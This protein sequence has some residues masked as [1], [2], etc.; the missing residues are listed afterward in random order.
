LGRL[1]R[2]RNGAIEALTATLEL[3]PTHEGAHFALSLLYAEAGDR[4]KART[5]RQAHHRLRAQAAEAEQ[6]RNAAAPRLEVKVR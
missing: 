6:K 4:E 1:L 3:N 5:H 2:G